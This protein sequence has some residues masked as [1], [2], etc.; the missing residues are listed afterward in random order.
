[1]KYPVFYAQLEPHSNGGPNAG[2]KLTQ[3]NVT[4]TNAATQAAGNPNGQGLFAKRKKIYVREVFGKFNNIRWLMVWLTQIAYF[5]TPWLTWNDRP[6]VWFDLQKR[7]FYIFGLTF[8]PSDIVYMTFLLI[9]CALALFLFTAVAGRVWCGY[10][11]PQTVYTEIFMWI[12]RKVEGNRTAQMR[13]DK[14]AWGLNKISRKGLKHLLWILVSLASSFTLVAYFTGAEGSNNAM[15]LLREIKHHETSFAQL[16]WIGL[17]G[18]MM[19]LFAGFM[20]EQVCLYMC[21][22]ARFQSVMF[23][24]DTLIVTYDAAR[25]ESRGARK[26]GVDPK[27]I[28][29]GDCIDCGV[30]VDVCPTGIDIRKGLQYE[31]IGCGACIDGC[32][33]IMHKMNYAP[34]LI[35]YDTENGLKNGYNKQQLLKRSVRPRVLVYIAILLI[36]M[37][38]MMFSIGTRTA[39]RM[40]VERDARVITRVNPE[41]LV[42]NVYKLQFSNTTEKWQTVK[43]SV[44]GAQG[45]KIV[46]KPEVE[47][48]P[49]Q[50]DTKIVIVQVNQERA[51]MAADGNTLPI[52]F[53]M[54]APDTG[55]E[56]DVKATYYLPAQ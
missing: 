17:Y 29:K 24:P 53:H 2:E 45:I 6:A 21:P 37:V 3:S 10:T 30:C 40:T 46:G 22:Y 39:I 26:K 55:D 56:L 19:Y 38:G 32:N 12:E 47:L 48:E 4:E 44:T 28:G 43:F 16:F 33:E 42:E 52:V 25:G 8:S 9:I 11:C 41:G 51:R 1:M 13:L 54:S 23:D 20:R 7:F 14:A 35:R 15:Q 18:F 5:V 27:S 31:C 36:L 49:A 34:G 50:P